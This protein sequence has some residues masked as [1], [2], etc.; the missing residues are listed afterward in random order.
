[1]NHDTENDFLNR[2]GTQPQESRG[3]EEAPDFQI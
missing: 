1:M 3:Q 2:L